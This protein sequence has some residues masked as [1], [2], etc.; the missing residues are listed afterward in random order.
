[1]GRRFE[2]LIFKW[3]VNLRLGQ[4]YYS[5]ASSQP[6]SRDTVPLSNKSKK[7]LVKL[8]SYLLLNNDIN[9][10]NFYRSLITK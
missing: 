4:S 2:Q 6:L 8:K 3:F 10:S 7:Y 9:K 1:M 5:M